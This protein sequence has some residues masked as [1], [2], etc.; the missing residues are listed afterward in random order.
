MMW[1]FSNEQDTPD[2]LPQGE[3]HRFVGHIEMNTSAVF[4][5]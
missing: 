3:V 2:L 5:L 4:S 1:G